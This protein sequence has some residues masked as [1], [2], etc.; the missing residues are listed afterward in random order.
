MENG[1]Q[2]LELVEILNKLNIK[3][4]RNF[5]RVLYGPVKV[6][7]KYKMAKLMDIIFTFNAT[8]EQRSEV[9][10]YIS[11]VPLKSL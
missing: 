4:N 5:T 2:A 9:Y 1:Q 10:R 7:Y 3:L 6:V 8:E 11:D